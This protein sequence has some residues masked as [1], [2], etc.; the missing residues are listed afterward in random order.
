[1]SVQPLP[2]FGALT[3]G[4]VTDNDDKEGRGRVKVSLASL[5]LELWAAVATNSAGKDYGVQCLPKKNEVVVVAFISPD[6]PVVLGSVWTGTAKP[7]AEQSPV[8]ERF[9]VVTPS[10]TRVVCDDRGGPKVEIRTPAGNHL[11]LTDEGGGKATVDVQG[12]TITVTSSKVSLKASGPVEVQGS[13]MKIEAATLTVNAS[14]ATFSGVVSCNTLQAG[15]VM[16]GA[17]SQGAG[18]VW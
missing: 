12:T 5:S 7:H 3:L 1:M 17:Y 10:G 15:S 6:L 2:P 8:Q 14:Q 18:N 9:A 16:S 4:I 13:T 11:T